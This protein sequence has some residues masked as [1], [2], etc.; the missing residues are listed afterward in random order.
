MKCFA[1]AAAVALPLLMTAAAAHAQTAEDAFGLWLDPSNGGH[2][3]VAKCEDRLCAK[4]AFVPDN[5]GK[6]GPKVDKNNPDAELKTRPILG[7]PLVEK[8]T[9]ANDK[10]W[11]GYIYS[12]VDGK[13]FAMTM[14]P[15]GPEKI[16][17]KGCLMGVL[18][19]TVT[20]TRVVK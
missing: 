10:E 15:K 3:E 1:L 17:V 2:I 14:T 18:C 12:P 4:V 13:S 16:D 20:W 8:A 9:K 7:M 6:D 5:D 19:R 11:Q